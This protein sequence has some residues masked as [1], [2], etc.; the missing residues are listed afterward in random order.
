[1]FLSLLGQPVYAHRRLRDCRYRRQ[2]QLLE[3]Q[4][5]TVPR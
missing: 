3:S 5:L 4:E 1:M 2:P